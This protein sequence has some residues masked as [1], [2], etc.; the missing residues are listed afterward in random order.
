MDFDGD[1]DDQASVS[2][3]L[4][5]DDFTQRQLLRFSL[6]VSDD[7][8]SSE[9]NVIIAVLP[10]SRPPLVFLEAFPKNQFMSHLIVFF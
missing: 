6:R 4:N 1:I 3:T 5:S 2:F 9:D 7:F 10:P 8:S